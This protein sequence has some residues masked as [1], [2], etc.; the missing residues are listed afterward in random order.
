MSRPRYRSPPGPAPGRRGEDA[1]LGV[2]GRD[3]AAVDQTWNRSESLLMLPPSLSALSCEPPATAAPCVVRGRHDREVQV[4]L[5]VAAGDLSGQHDGAS[6]PGRAPAAVRNVRARIV[7]SIDLIEN[8]DSLV[9]FLH[10]QERRPAR[11]LVGE[12]RSPQS[13]DDLEA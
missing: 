9:R 5:L 1:H 2:L 7:E 4:A 8:F 3:H 6:S 13:V 10:E 11:R 12:F